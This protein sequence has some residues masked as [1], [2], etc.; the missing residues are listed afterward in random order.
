MITAIAASQID[1]LVA[2][3]RLP[4]EIPFGVELAPVMY[5]AEFSG[6]EWQPGSLV[7]FA[8]VPVNP[9]STAFALDAYWAE[10]IAGR[11]EEARAI[12]QAC[13][14]HGGP[15]PFDLE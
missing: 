15:L 12:L 6:G 4:D 14:D 5:R 3:Y 11:E 8:D 13:A 10:L 7:P 9:A 1:R 2:G